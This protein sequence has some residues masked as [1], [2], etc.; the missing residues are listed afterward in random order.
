[1]GD[2]DSFNIWDVLTTESGTTERT[3][4]VH[5]INPLFM[6]R[7]VWFQC[8]HNLIPTAPYNNT[9]GFDT[10]KGNSAYRM[11]NWKLL[12]GDPGMMIFH[13]QP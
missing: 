2:L 13:M 10:T 1:M 9:H 7:F 4:L 5:N 8:G 11:N 3:E 12:T 6:S